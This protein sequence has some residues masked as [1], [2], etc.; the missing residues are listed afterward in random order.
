MPA[1]VEKTKGLK[2]ALTLTSDF[3]TALKSVQSDVKENNPLGE[4]SDVILSSE[5]V[6]ILLIESKDRK[7]IPVFICKIC[8]EQFRKQAEVDVHLRLHSQPSSVASPIIKMEDSGAPIDLSPESGQKRSSEATACTVCEQTFRKLADLEEHMSKSHETSHLRSILSQPLSSSKKSQQ[9]DDTVQF[10]NEDSDASVCCWTCKAV[11]ATKD[12]LFLHSISQQ[13]PVKVSAFTD[14]RPDTVANSLLSPAQL[15]ALASFQQPS[16]FIIP[17]LLNPLF[18]PHR[19]AFSTPATATRGPSCAVCHETFQTNLEMVRHCILLGHF[20]TNLGGETQQISS[21]LPASTGNQANG[22]EFQCRFCPAVFSALRELNSHLHAAHECSF[23]PVT[24]PTVPASKANG[25]QS[26]VRGNIPMNVQPQKPNGLTLRQLVYQPEDKEGFDHMVSQ[27]QS[28]IKVPLASS[29]GGTS[30]SSSS[31]TEDSVSASPAARSCS[32]APPMRRRSSLSTI[33]GSTGGSLL[34]SLLA[35]T[36]TLGVASPTCPASFDD[37]V[38]EM[39]KP[40][41]PSEPES[42]CSASSLKRVL[43]GKLSLQ[44]ELAKYQPFKQET[45]STPPPSIL[46]RCLLSGERPLSPVATSK[47]PSPPPLIPIKIPPNLPPSNTL[48]DDETPR[49]D[50]VCPL[51]SRTFTLKSSLK[52]H[53]KKRHQQDEGEDSSPPLVMVEC[54]VQIDGDSGAEEDPPQEQPLQLTVKL[55]DEPSR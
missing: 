12:E 20:E 22:V 53:L 50:I 39:K 11:F 41:T 37:M 19:P 13:C 55:K 48:D 21:S 54:D 6:A 40:T 2:E 38:T 49:D 17:P 23:R 43:E 7:P 32:P 4:R 44:G 30:S 5:K 1:D 3:A 26:A 33:P 9:N 52:R 8:G 31:V 25:G 18:F 29:E 10:K 46:A 24:S 14:N 36:A 45:S 34:N 42:T 51:C 47:A 28:K 15:L 16:P 27:M 35:S